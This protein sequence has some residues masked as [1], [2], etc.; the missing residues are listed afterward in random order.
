MYILR[1]DQLDRLIDFNLELD[2]IS[3]I[4][5]HLKFIDAEIEQR[6]ESQLDFILEECSYVKGPMTMA[7]GIAMSHMTSP[8]SRSMAAS[9][10]FERDIFKTSGVRPVSALIEI[11]DGTVRT[12][13]PPQKNQ[14]LKQRI[15][16]LKQGLL[17]QIAEGDTQAQ[18]Q[19]LLMLAFMLGITNDSESR[20]QTEKEIKLWY[21]PDLKS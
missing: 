12:G 18:G 9:K 13:T 17:E 20:R 16:N 2:R 6:L 5:Q 3:G 1:Q 21:V 7:I 8:G 10:L 11:Y 14:A 15:D 4:E 19:R